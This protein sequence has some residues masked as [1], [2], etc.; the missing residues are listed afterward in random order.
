MSQTPE[1]LPPAAGPVHRLR[2]LDFIET[3]LRHVTAW[4][5]VNW[6]ADLPA[7]HIAAHQPDR[8]A[9]RLDV[10]CRDAGQLEACQEALAADGGAVIHQLEVYKNGGSYARYYRRFGTVTVSAW[11]IIHN[12]E[13]FYEAEAKKRQ[14]EAGKMHGRGQDQLSP[15]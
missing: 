12:L 14:A 1:Q 9:L 13:S 6:P 5:V 15:N 4:F 3:D 10:Y 7:P 8:T 2:Y 11:R